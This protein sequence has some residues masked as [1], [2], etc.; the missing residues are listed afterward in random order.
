M[1]EVRTNT[2]PLRALHI[3][4]VPLQLKS[5]MHRLIIHLIIILESMPSCRL[6][7]IVGAIKETT[8]RIK[9]SICAL[10]GRLV[11]LDSL[12]SSIVCIECDCETVFAL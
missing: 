12:H 10:F 6:D 5:I 9:I 8:N 1:N 7:Y 11:S 4:P 3:I 2:M